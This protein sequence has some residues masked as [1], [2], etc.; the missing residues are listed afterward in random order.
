MKEI[1]TVA[2]NF[3]AIITESGKILPEIEIALVLSEPV[4]RPHQDGLVIRERQCETIRFSLSPKRA[5]DL[6]KQLETLADECTAEFDKAIQL[7]H[8]A[9]ME[10]PNA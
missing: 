8:N 4:Y 1:A 9:N 5:I 6:A 3:L 7:K 10:A 2:A